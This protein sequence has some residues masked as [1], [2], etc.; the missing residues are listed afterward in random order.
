LMLGWFRD[1]IDYALEV[2]RVGAR[3]RGGGSDEPGHKNVPFLEV[4]M[5]FSH[6]LGPQDRVST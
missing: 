5:E 6:K 1:A 2:K 3:R 4:I